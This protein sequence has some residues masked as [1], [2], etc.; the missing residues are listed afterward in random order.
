MGQRVGAYRGEC[1]LASSAYQGSL[2]TNDFVEGSIAQLDDWKA[3]YQRPY[4]LNLRIG[5]R[6]GPT[7][8]KHVSD[9]HQRDGDYDVGG[10]EELW[11]DR[12]ISGCASGL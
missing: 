2:F 12:A 9:L 6:S 10:A 8:V 4:C 7:P 3:L 5:F 11:T 1:S